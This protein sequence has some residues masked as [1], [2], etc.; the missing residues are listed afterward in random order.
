MYKFLAGLITFFRQSVGMNHKQD[1]NTLFP[2]MK[3]KSLQILIHNIF[4]TYQD[5]I[6][7]S[8]I[9]ECYN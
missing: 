6:N 5:Q 3:S 4:H 7:I 9:Y 1:K 8:K 2:L